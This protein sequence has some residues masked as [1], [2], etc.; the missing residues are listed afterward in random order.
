[1]TTLVHRVIINELV[2]TPL[3]PTSWCAIDLA[4][5]DCDG[6][7]NVDVHRVKVVGVVLPVESRGRGSGVG[8]PVERDVV[9]RLVP[10]EFFLGLA[11]GVS[12]IGELVIEP[13]REPDR[14][15]EFAAASPS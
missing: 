5:K 2:I 12:P 3:G 6:S 8:E 9:E 13:R 10:R 15:P 14:R 1:V 4:G 7:G 11:A